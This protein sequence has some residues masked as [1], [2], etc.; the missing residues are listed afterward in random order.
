M[1]THQYSVAPLSVRTRFLPSVVSLASVMLCLS[2]TAC[3]KD[4]PPTAPL[5]TAPDAPTTVSA[6]IG[7][8][9][10][11]LA[12][13]APTDDGGSVITGYVATCAAG[14]EQVKATGTSSPIVVSGL[15]NGT[16]Y[17]CVVAATNS[18]GVGDASAAVLVTPA[19]SE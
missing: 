14:G 12:F 19:A 5:V 6:A 4:D 7:D 9:S 3:G 18:V 8:A 10:V 13:V 1:T 11:S 17:G 2:L 15:T 16:Q